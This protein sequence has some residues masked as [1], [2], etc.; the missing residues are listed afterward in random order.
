LARTTVDSG[1]VDARRKR[2]IG[3]VSYR[4]FHENQSSDPSLRTEQVQAALAEALRLFHPRDVVAFE[5][6]HRLCGV[7]LHP[8]ENGDAALLRADV[9]FPDMEQRA[10]AEGLNLVLE[11][12]LHRLLQGLLN[13]ADTDGASGGREQEPLDEQITEEVRFP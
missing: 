10:H 13:L 6:L 4:G 1:G 12:P 9:R 3:S 11:Q 5:R 2:S 8:L 7:V